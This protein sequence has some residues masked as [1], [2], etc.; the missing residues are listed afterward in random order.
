MTIY[1]RMLQSKEEAARILCRKTDCNVCPAEQLC[2]TGHNGLK[3][4]LSMEEDVPA[5]WSDP[6]EEKEDVDFSQYMNKPEGD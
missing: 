6:D 3:E 2:R 4:L 1:E 5:Y